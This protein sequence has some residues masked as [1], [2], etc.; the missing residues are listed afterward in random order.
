VALETNSVSCSA[1]RRP[2]CGLTED[3]NFEDPFASFVH[4]RGSTSDGQRLWTVLTG[5]HSSRIGDDGVIIRGLNETRAVTDGDTRRLCH[6]VYNSSLG[7]ESAVSLMHSVLDG[8]SQLF[9]KV[10]ISS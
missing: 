3:R 2:N 6:S 4:P 5:F 10:L 1:I 8:R 9:H 7:F